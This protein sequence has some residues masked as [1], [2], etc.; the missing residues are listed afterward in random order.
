MLPLFDGTEHQPETVG[1]GLSAPLS[2][3]YHPVGVYDLYAFMDG[4]TLRLGTVA[5]ASLTARATDI[6]Q[7]R[8]LWA[9]KAAVSVRFGTGALDEASVAAS[10]GLC[11]GSV[12]L[13]EAG[14]TADTLCK[15]YVSNIYNQ[16]RRKMAV[17]G[18][19]SAYAYGTA[20]WRLAKGSAANRAYYLQSLGGGEITAAA[21]AAFVNS[22]SSIAACQSGIGHDADDASSATHRL[23]GSASNTYYG[24]CSASLVDVAQIGLHYLSWLEYG[25]GGGFTPTWA[26]QP[27]HGL[28][29]S[30]WL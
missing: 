4:V 12:Y 8:G 7:V 6:Q 15:R 24:A 5:W 20:A 19:G 23:T 16:V 30:I 27:F 13:N 26:N 2:A 3:A 18:D 28:S 9:N 22:T 1:S 21:A 17:T 14:V 25:S 10:S 11:L 29:G